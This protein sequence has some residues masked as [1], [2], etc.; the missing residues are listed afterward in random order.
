VLRAIIGGKSSAKS[1]RQK[2]RHGI[3][4][5]ALLNWPD[6]GLATL[7]Q[8]PTPPAVLRSGL[9]RTPTPGSV[10]VGKVAL[11]FVAGLDDVFVQT[12]VDVMS[13]NEYV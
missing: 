12:T 9:E 6:V 2:G 11:Q 4:T 10:Q 5:P 7:D 13:S 1:W 8:Q 3:V